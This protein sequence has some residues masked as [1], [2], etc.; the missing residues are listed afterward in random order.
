MLLPAAARRGLLLLVVLVEGVRAQFPRECAGLEVLQ[1]GQCC[2]ALTAEPGDRC[3]SSL[4]RGSCADLRADP[5]PHGPQYPHDGEDD[6]ERWP[7]RFFNRTCRCAANYQGY[8][9]GQCRF[10]WAGADCQQ[11]VLRV[12]RDVLSLSTSQRARLVRALHLAKTTPH[13]DMVVATRHY[14]DILGSDG[15]SPQFDNVSIYNLFVWTHYYSV[16]RTY[17]GDGRSFGGVDFSHEGP[18]F[19]TWHR[20]HLLCAIKFSIRLNFT[21]PLFTLPYWNFATGSNTCDVCTDDLMGAR[22]NFDSVLISPNSVFSEW[23]N[24]CESIEDYN[25]L[26]T[27]CNGTEGGPIQRNPGGNVARPAVQRLPSPEDVAQCLDVSPYDTPPFFSNSSDSFRN[28]VEGKYYDPAVRSLHNLAH[29]FLNG[30]GGQTHLSPNDPI[31]VLLHTFTDAIFDEWLKRSQA[32]ASVFPFENAPIGHNRGYNIVP[33]WPPITNAEMFK[34]AAENFG[35][36]YEVQW[37]SKFTLNVFILPLGK[38]KVSIESI[39]LSAGLAP[40]IDGL[41]LILNKVCVEEEQLGGLELFKIHST[42][43]IHSLP[44]SLEHPRASAQEN[45]DDP[46]F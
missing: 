26:G 11:P 19:L 45:K 31:F 23:R 27:I 13:P 18:A 28:T 15:R 38:Q 40:S 24:L 9:C 14:A 29:L 33:F 36:T 42:C 43:A 25:T 1:S 7:L 21:D 2:P 41:K 5:A 35:Y 17:L 20:F 44:Y 10:G 8:K 6:R 22:S 30:T 32:D 3:G 46:Y 16:S 34:P 12:R 39:A 4:G 37:P